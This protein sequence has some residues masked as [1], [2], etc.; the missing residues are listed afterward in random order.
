MIISAILAGVTAELQ[1]LSWVV[2]VGLAALGIA[3]ATREAVEIWGEHRAHCG[4]HETHDRLATQGMMSA[5]G[6]CARCGRPPNSAR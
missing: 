2:V 3:G 6:V 1:V 5:G 4:L